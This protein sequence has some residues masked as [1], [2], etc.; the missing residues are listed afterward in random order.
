LAEPAAAT[1]SER[2]RVIE[3]IVLVACLALF[4]LV[5]LL[6]HGTELGYG[7]TRKHVGILIAAGLTLIMYSFLYRDNPLFK[8]AENFYVGISLGYGIITTWYL[9]LKTELYDPFFAAPTWDAVWSAVLE[10]FIPITL[11]CMLVTRI[12]RRFSWPSRYAYALMIGWGA[13]IGIPITIHTYVLQQLEAAVRPLNV[14]A[15]WAALRGPGLLS[16]EFWSAFGVIF[17]A[18]VI[19]VGTVTV[20]FYFFFSLERK[21]I[22][23]AIS[24]VGI[25]FL[26]VSFGAS[27]G[28]TVMGRISLFIGRAQFLLD[29][30]LGGALQGIV[31]DWLG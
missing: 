29:Q 14:K 21:R 26:M 27:F 18:F 3:L 19:L 7:D 28:Y 1:E 5:S 15:A 23:N 17:G 9:S 31:R 10:R 11:G 22:G 25:L 30:W 16:Y 6:V 20:L 24:R 8:A 4:L 12:S 2:R 13:G